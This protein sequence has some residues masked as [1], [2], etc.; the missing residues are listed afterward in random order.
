MFFDGL[1]SPWDGQLM[2]CFAEATSGKYEFTRQA[3]D[4]FATESVRRAKAAISSGSFD[5]EVVPVSAKTRK[6]EALVDKDET[7]STLDRIENSHAEACL[8]ARTAR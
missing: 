8:S 2:G 1:Q 7:P 6:G 3:Q 5:A 4:D